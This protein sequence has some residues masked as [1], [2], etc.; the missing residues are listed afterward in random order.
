MSGIKDV[1][2]LIEGGVPAG[3]RIPPG[4]EGCRTKRSRTRT[5]TMH[6]NSKTKPRGIEIDELPLRRILRRKKA[7]REKLRPFSREESSMGRLGVEGS[8]LE[9]RCFKPMGAVCPRCR[10]NADGTE[11][12]YHDLINTSGR[13]PKT[14]LLHLGPPYPR[15]EFEGQNHSR[16]ASKEEA[17]LLRGCQP[18][19]APVI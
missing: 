11:H 17:R 2:N 9:I 10:C 13:I 1:A 5:I 4:D 19:I 14:G 18:Q 3:I 8:H 16:H 12:L 6:G 7:N 15:N